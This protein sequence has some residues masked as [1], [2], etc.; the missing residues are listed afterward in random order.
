VPQASRIGIACCD[1]AHNQENS[2]RLEESIAIAKQKTHGLGHIQTRGGVATH[3][4]R[5]GHRGAELSSVSPAS[6]DNS[7]FL[8]FVCSELAVALT[9]K[10]EENLSSA[11]KVLG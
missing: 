7:Q 5:S 10:A 4:E 2:S 3:Y 8:P 1:T 11:L 6:G 9:T